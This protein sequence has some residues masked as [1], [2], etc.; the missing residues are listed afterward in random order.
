MRMNKA[1]TILFISVS[2]NSPIVNS[3]TTS[4][5]GI[6]DRISSAFSSSGN[7]GDSVNTAGEISQNKKN[8]RDLAALLLADYLPSSEGYP[9]DGV[10]IGQGWYR[11]LGKKSMNRCVTGVS[12]PIEGSSA[13]SSFK[14]IY[15]REELATSLKIS[16]S[17]SYGSA[18]SASSSYSKDTS[19]IK[20]KRNI[21]SQIDVDKGGVQLAPD[22][23]LDRDDPQGRLFPKYQIKFTPEAL[24]ILTSPKDNAVE[25]LKKFRALCGDSFVATIR[26]GGK[27]VVKFQFD[28]T[29]SSMKESFEASASGG[30]GGFGGSGSISRSVNTAKDSSDTSVDSYQLGGE[31]TIPINAAEAYAKISNFAN[32][33]SD[34]SAPYSITVMPYQAISQWPQALNSASVSD[35]YLKHL[36][37]HMWRLDELSR[38]YDDAVLNSN[39]Y[40]FPFQV[41]KEETVEARKDEIQKQLIR[42]SDILKAASYCISGFVSACA[43]YGECEEAS[44][45][46]YCPK[47][48]WPQKS[49]FLEVLA[50]AF[51]SRTLEAGKDSL[52]SDAESIIGKIIKITGSESPPEEASAAKDKD[53]PAGDP[54]SLYYRYLARSPLVRGPADSFSNEAYQVYKFCQSSKVSDDC[55]RI[56]PKITLSPTDQKAELIYSRWV[57]S[58]RLGLI[59]TSF[60]SV[61]IH[62]P[63]CRDVTELLNM[64]S[65]LSANLGEDRNYIAEPPKPS[66]PPKRE[67]VPR[68]EKP[69]CRPASICI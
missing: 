63:M 66:H 17:G 60:C 29:E 25:K 52:G 30:Y 28:R 13:T 46:N 58:F 59:S 38:V 31:L 18:F 24:V 3:D 14:E 68:P 41:T 50:L 20:T 47:F 21:L 64:G 5:P 4:D 40:Y 62:H 12:V 49:D 22:A 10:V 16:A 36:V 69:M 35:R 42:N 7:A 37:G 8:S 54:F 32:F 15:D 26:N 2:L 45:I 9:V 44:A 61:D 34:K 65:E 33:P 23:P 53:L 11:G 1:A 55:E 43:L 19:L 57:S 6:I 27:Y 67:P 51:P 39:K 56:N 48:D